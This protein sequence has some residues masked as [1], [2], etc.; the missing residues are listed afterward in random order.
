MYYTRARQ[1]REIHQ[2]VYPDYKFKPNRKKRDSHSTSRDVPLSEKDARCA[3]LA[4]ALMPEVLSAT[5]TWP[6]GAVALP[7]VEHNVT[8]TVTSMVSLLSFF[9][10]KIRTD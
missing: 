7:A 10:P 4:S 9:Q 3:R 2:Q 8:R 1:L 6:Q 5:S